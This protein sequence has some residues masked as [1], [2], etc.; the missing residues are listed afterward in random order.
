[1]YTRTTVPE[2]TVDDADGHGNVRDAA[3]STQQ[4]DGRSDLTALVATSSFGDKCH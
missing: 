3:D 1:M 2:D 4:N